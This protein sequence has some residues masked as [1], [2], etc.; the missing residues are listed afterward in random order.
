M[1][2][3]SNAAHSEFVTGAVAAAVF[4]PW[5]VEL[6]LLWC[7]VSVALA[8]SLWALG[9]TLHKAYRRFGVPGAICLAVLIASWPSDAWGFF[10]TALAF[11]VMV[12]GASLGYGIPSIQP[13]DAGSA[14]G[15]FWFDIFDENE[16]LANVAT[17]ATVGLVFGTAGVFLGGA[18]WIL[19][20]VVCPLGFA[21]AWLALDK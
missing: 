11:G 18:W 3:L 6:G 12:L 17:R 14:I 15:S 10:G 20:V 21:L 2:K 8:A 19:P 5:Y 7:V 4:L 13:E 1:S 16:R 9:G